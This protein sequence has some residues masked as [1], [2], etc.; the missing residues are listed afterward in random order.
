MKNISLK[1]IKHESIKAIFNAIADAEKI[2]RAEISEKTDLSLVTIGKIADALLYLDIICQAKEVRPQAGRRAGLL[3]VN[4]S[5]F[6][7]ILDLTSYDFRVAV[8]NA[9]LCMIER[10][11][12]TYRK[13]LSFEENLGCFFAETQAEIDGKYSLKNCFGV[14]IAVSGPYNSES[15]SVISSRVPELCGVRLK[16]FAEKYFPLLPI[17][18]DSQVNAAAKSNI[19]HVENYT[20]KNIVYWYI[21]NSYVCGAYLVGGKLIL[22]KDGH[23]CQFGGIRLDDGS[24]LEETLDKCEDIDSYAMHLSQAV[25]TVIKILSP[26]LLIIEYDTQFKCEDIIPP[27]KKN[28]V[29]IY[30]I[31]EKNMPEMTRACCKFRNSHRGLTLDLREMWLDR[32]I[33]ANEDE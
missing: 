28:L 25:G 17:R 2:S 20:E 21:G 29:E 23:A 12:F 15:D 27:I 3:S 22:G 19:R 31:P 32:V 9:R 5:K 24:T 6:A 14:G 1:S 8:L 16:N 10:S 7:L 13:E 33:A 30:G 4:E 11:I 18:I 26:H